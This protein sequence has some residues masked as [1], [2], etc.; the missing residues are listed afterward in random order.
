LTLNIEPVTKSLLV[1]RSRL[2]ETNAGVF[3]RESEAYLV[4]PCIFPDEIHQLI[5]TVNK[6]RAQLRGV[7]LTHSHWDHILGPERI[8]DVPVIAHQTA[9]AN[10]AANLP[11]I[12]RVVADRMTAHH[13]SRHAPFEAPRIDVEVGAALTLPFGAGGLRLIHAP[14]HCSDQLVVYETTERTL[15]A[16]DMLSDLEI[17]FIEDSRAY[18]KTLDRL[19]QLDI[20]TLVPGHGNATN[21]HEEIRGRFMS[22]RQYLTTLDDDVGRL[23]KRGRSLDEITQ[24]LAAQP[25]RHREI[26]AKEHLRNIETVYRDLS[27]GCE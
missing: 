16:A 5:R 23:A 21:D 2:Y 24:E 22:D 17:P 26:N 18:R 7:I 10:L 27:R 3:V 14:G 8:P 9:A 19:M 12:A 20:A 15:W 13:F 1:G 6:R 25:L 11:E 4:D